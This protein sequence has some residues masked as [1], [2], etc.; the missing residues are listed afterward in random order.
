V[1]ADDLDRIARAAELAVLAGDDLL[2]GRAID[3]LDDAIVNRFPARARERDLDEQL[4]ALAVRQ[5]AATRAAAPCD[6]LL[7]V[8]VTKG[9]GRSLGMRPTYERHGRV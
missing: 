5:L 7:A 2:L 6:P 8:G 1:A 9:S 3:A 4:H